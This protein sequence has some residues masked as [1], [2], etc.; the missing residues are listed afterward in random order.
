MARM[1]GAQWQGEKSPKRLMTEYSILCLHTI[2]G[3]APAHAAHFSVKADGTILQSRDTRYR[4]AA[5]LNGNHRI[6]AIENEDHGSAF[7]S[8]NVN[9]G[10]AVPDFTPQQIEANAKILAWA[11]KT[12][13]IPLQL[14]PNS[15][16]SSRGL[17]FHR[18]G[19]DG[20][21]EGYKYSGRVSG[22]EVWSS[23]RGKVCPGDR[24][25][26]RRPQILDRAKQIVNGDWLD[27]ATKNDVK[28]AVREVLFEQIVPRYDT[29]ADEM[30]PK[31]Y[32]VISTL[33]WA[34]RKA[35]EGREA[36]TLRLGG[37]GH[38]PR[39]AIS[40]SEHRTAALVN[41]IEAQRPLLEAAAEGN[42]LTDAQVQEIAA[43]C[44]AAVPE[45][46]AEDVLDEL[47]DAIVEQRDEPDDED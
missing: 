6:I 18:Q 38:T 15:K 33:Y 8:W 10:H 45:E 28:A 22:G 36:M 44:A 13:G 24:R 2:V 4:S 31:K 30:R 43:A 11:H 7:G 32:S 34:L 20:N 21:W 12:H 35:T 41:M 17:A 1:P 47:A 9:D 29:Q 5:N 16:P 39:Q 14:C 37:D 23:A 25:I 42:A 3:Y 27:M 19:I 40:L 26:A 46:I